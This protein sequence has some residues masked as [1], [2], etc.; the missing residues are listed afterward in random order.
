M[1]NLCDL[2]LIILTFILLTPIILFMFVSIVY[3]FGYIYDCLFGNWIIQF[4]RYIG[5]K[6]PRIKN[7]EKAFKLWE[8]IRPQKLYLRYETP[9]FTYCGSFT[10]IVL[11]SGIFNYNYYIN[12]T[13]GCILYLVLYFVGMARRCRDNDEYYDKVLKNNLDFLKLSFLPLGFIITILGFLCTITG[14][15]V[16]DLSIPL[17]YLDS[18]KDSVNYFNLEL[19]SFK[20]FLET[21]LGGVFIFII[22]YILSLPV[23]VVSYFII[24]LIDYFRKNNDGYMRLY[25]MYIEQIINYFKD[26][27]N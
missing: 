15:R 4:C 23:Q 21:I 12:L 3:I 5:K 24:S 27:L 22:F 8:I 6:Y 14:V 9:L 2:I 18:L 16:Q 10:A 11:L 17:Q 1:T 26:I 13:I 19:Y 7:S 25:K 20:L